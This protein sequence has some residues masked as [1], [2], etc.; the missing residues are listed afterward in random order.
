MYT[1]YKDIETGEI[2]SREELEQEYESLKATG[3]TEAVSAGAYISN[4]MTWNN[5][6]LTPHLI[7]R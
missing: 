4:C 1:L 2:V 3:D 6:T 7:E 5:G